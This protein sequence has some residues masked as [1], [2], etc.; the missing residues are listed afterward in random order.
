M[1]CWSAGVFVEGLRPARIRIHNS[2][3]VPDTKNFA[4]NQD[5]ALLELPRAAQ[6]FGHGDP[7]PHARSAALT[8]I[9]GQEP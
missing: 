1:E 5:P 6:S 7:K 2:R 4:A 3:T 8:E 9:M